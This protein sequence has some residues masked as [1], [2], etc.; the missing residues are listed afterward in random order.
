M[1]LAAGSLAVEAAELR[2]GGGPFEQ[3]QVDVLD[4]VL[5]LV[6]ADEH[7]VGQVVEDA[8]GEGLDVADVEERLGPRQQ[9]ATH[10]PAR[11]ARPAARLKRSEATSARVGPLA[12]TV[13]WRG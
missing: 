12:D 7:P 5:V 3:L 2:D 13:P 8:A 11:L 10:H 1:L 9:P 4:L 6:L